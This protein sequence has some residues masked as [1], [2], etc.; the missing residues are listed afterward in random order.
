MNDS[1]A[2]RMTASNTTEWNHSLYGIFTPRDDGALHIP[3]EAV[4]DAKLAGLVVTPEPPAVPAATGPLV[5]A[6]GSRAVT[7]DLGDLETRLRL[8]ELSDWHRIVG[9]GYAAFFDSTG[10]D[11]TMS[12]AEATTVLAAA[13]RRQHAV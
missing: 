8:L 13:R 4:P 1:P 7:L 12:K 10:A 3:A 5:V 11:C 6:L 2:V 9:Q